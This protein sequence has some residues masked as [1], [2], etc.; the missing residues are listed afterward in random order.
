M[1]RAVRPCNEEMV[2]FISLEDILR[3]DGSYESGDLSFIHPFIHSY[4]H[5]LLS[6]DL[7]SDP[8]PGHSGEPEAAFPPGS[9]KQT[10]AFHRDRGFARGHRDLEGTQKRARLGGQGT[11]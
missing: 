7:K 3:R 6:S 4:K 11:F 9:D 1:R 10:G 8:T 2:P 5:C